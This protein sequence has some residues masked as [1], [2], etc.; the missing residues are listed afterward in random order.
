MGKLARYKSQTIDIDSPM[1]TIRP[2][3]RC[4]RC[5]YGFGESNGRDQRQQVN[6]PL[7]RVAL[8]QRAD[9][10]QGY[11]V[12]CDQCHTHVNQSLGLHP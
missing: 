4:H 9:Y 3:E 1:V 2:P 7:K 6:L 12:W 8:G 11:I 5:H 10:S